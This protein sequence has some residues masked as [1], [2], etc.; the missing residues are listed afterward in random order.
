MRFSLHESAC[1]CIRG[2]RSSKPHVYATWLRGT[3]V[4]LFFLHSE[5][6]NCDLSSVW[7]AINDNTY[8]IEP[9]LC[10]NANNLP[11]WTWWQPHVTQNH[12]PPLTSRAKGYAPPEY[13]LKS[14]LCCAVQA[15]PDYRQGLQEDVLQKKHDFIHYKWPSYHQR[16]IYTSISQP[17]GDTPR[18]Y[19]W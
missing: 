3:C 2:L 10:H 13:M 14:L 12:S 16:L 5:S 4:Y 6:L 18:I 1:I 15:P 7:V 19:T 8:V 17:S 9:N 11:L